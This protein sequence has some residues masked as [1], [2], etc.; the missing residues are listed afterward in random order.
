M[1]ARLVEESNLKTPINLAQHSYFNLAP[2]KERSTT[3]GNKNTG[4]C[5]HGILD[6]TLMLESDFYTPKD[7]DAIPTRQV[8][9]L[10]D[11][12]VMDISTKPHRLRDVIRRYAMEIMGLSNDRAE[13]DLLHRTPA[14]PYGIDDN[15]VLR[16]QPCLALRKVA[17][18]QYKTRTLTVHTTSPGVQVYTGNFLEEDN[19]SSSPHKEP[20]KPWAG[21][22][23]ETQSFPDSIT[24]SNTDMESLA[25]A[26]G[27]C[28]VLTPQHREYDHIVEYTV[29]HSG[30]TMGTDTEGRQFDSIESMWAAQ[31]VSTWYKKS[32][33]YYEDNCPSTVDGVLGNLGWLSD[34][35][36]QGS[37]T[38]LEQ[39]NIEHVLKDG[40]ACECG[41]GIGR[42][43]KGLLLS[44]CSRCDIVESSPRL[45]SAAPD[46]I[47]E[48]SSRCRYF[49]SELQNWC[50]AQP[51]VLIW[52]QWTAIYLTDKDFVALLKRCASSL[53]PGGVIV[54]KE[55]TCAEETFVLDVEDASVTRSLPYWRSLIFQ[56][57]LRVV[58]ESWQTDFPD[59]IFPVPMMALQPISWP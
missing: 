56:A 23:L 24:E 44:L 34:D 45:L 29:D 11:H 26:R 30:G 36:I 59:D 40:I 3:I 5:T 22:C 6:H 46:Y 16:E 19:E 39:L 31:H 54:L 32:S 38:F 47:G 53:V 2:N 49:C 27:K 8:V 33:E 57:G 21:I 55:N 50:P 4:T 10:M 13:A 52:I 42:V 51:Y 41:A 9:A 18:L 20:Y 14:R 7:P 25:F 17:T 12:S 48:D 37:R 28:Q 15:Y 43:T 35:D 1:K 58:K